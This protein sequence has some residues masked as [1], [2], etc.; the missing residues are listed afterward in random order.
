MS[1]AIET[2]GALHLEVERKHERAAV[3]V[4]LERDER[5][6]T[7]DWRFHRQIIRVALWLRERAGLEPGDRVA[8]VAPL[9]HEALVIDWATV[10]QGS[11]LVVLGP[12]PSAA[13]LETTFS[14][15]A[16]RIVFVAGAEAL[17]RVVE[18]GGNVVSLDGDAPEGVTSFAQA[19]E[20]GGTLDTAERAGAFRDRARAIK[21]SSDAIVHLEDVVG[22]APRC[23]VLTHADVMAERR[24]LLAEHPARRGDLA[25]AYPDA[26]STAAHV[27]LYT[28]VGDGLTS[29]AIGTAGR[30]LDEISR[31][32]PGIVVTRT[33]IV[34]RR[35]KRSSYDGGGL[36]RWL[37]RTLGASSGGST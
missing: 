22:G 16:P 2:L 26:L 24:R 25:Y 27:A 3:L 35:A 34:A 14:R 29:T 32:D 37:G 8:L 6:A 36:R 19:L 12:E 10:T 23:D 17:R 33:G 15:F 13:A 1:E 30:E 9:S 11:T 31:L 18:R 4:R 20:L 5:L 21:R 28:L 7:P